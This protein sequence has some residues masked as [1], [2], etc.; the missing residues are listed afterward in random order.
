M[1]AADTTTVN[2]TEVRNGKLDGFAATIRAEEGKI[3]TSLEKIGR[4]LRKAAPLFTADE[5][6]KWQKWS[7]QVTGWSFS[8]VKNVMRATVILDELSGEAADSVKTW[9]LDAVHQLSPVVV[10]GEDGEQDDEATAALRAEVIAQVGDTRPSP[11]TVR[12]TRDEVTGNERRQVSEDERNGKLADK[13]NDQV[14][15]HFAAQQTKLSSVMFG[16]GLQ[17]EHRGDVAAAVGIIFKRMSD[18]AEAAKNAAGSDE[19]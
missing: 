19:S 7:T 17:K 10:N 11:E 1:S 12:N 2:D 15:E 6:D 14:R 18:E 5:V 9:T 16:A 13:L 8:R 4:T 3:R